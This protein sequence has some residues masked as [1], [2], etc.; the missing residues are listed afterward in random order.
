MTTQEQTD[1]LDAAA[2]ADLIAD[3]DCAIRHAI[4]AE[5]E[6]DLARAMDLLKYASECRRKAYVYRNGGAHKAII[7]G[8]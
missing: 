1:E 8:G 2:V 5:A 6:H 7:A 3:A 4:E